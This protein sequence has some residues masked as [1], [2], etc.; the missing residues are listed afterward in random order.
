ML[1]KIQYSFAAGEFSPSLYGRVDQKKYHAGASTCRNMFINYRGGAYS[2]AGLAYVGTCLQT[3]INRNNNTDYIPRDI[4]FQFNVNQGYALEFGDQYMRIKTNGAYVTEAANAITGITKANPGVFSYTNTNYT[5][6]NG[7]WVLLSGILGMTSAT[8]VN[9]VKSFNGL[10]WIVYNVSG[11]TFSVKDLFGNP[12]DTT[13]FSTYTSGGTLKRIY[14]V[15]APYAA[16]DLP[17]L[18]FTQSADTM[19]LCCVN[20]QT[21]TE[22]PPYELVRN[23]LTNW[24]FTQ[25]NFSAPISPPTNVVAT[26]QS[27]TTISTYY[28]YV[29]TSVDAITGDE[30]VASSAASVQ[31]NDISV[32]AGSNT[33]TWTNVPAA[34]SYNVY[35]ATP[36]YNAPVGVGSSYGYIGNAFSTTFTDTNIIQNF[37]RTPPIHNNPFATKTITG[38]TIT[39]GGS[40]IV[41]SGISYTISTGTGSGL[42]AIPVVVGGALADFVIENG[43]SGYAPADTITINTNANGSYTFT[44]IPTN[45]QTIVLNGVTW[46][47]TTGVPGAASTKIQATAQA[48]V[49]Q[50]A[51]DLNASANGSINVATYSVQ[52]LILEIVYKTTGVGGNAYTLAAGTYAGTVSGATLVGGTSGGPTAALVIG[53]TAGTYPGAVA[54]FQQR[55]GYANTK[56]QPDEYFFSRPGSFTNFDSSTPSLA[57]DSVVGAPW[58]QQINGVQFMQPMTAGLIILTGQGA[59]L[60]NGGSSSAFTPSSQTATA[61][62]YNGC[63]P[64]IPPILIN[65]N[66][67]YVQEKGYLVRDLTYNFYLNVFTGDDKTIYAGHLFNFYQLTQWAW[68]E[69]PWKVVWAVRND[70]A[71]LSLT[72]LK[73]QDVFAW[74]R[75]D[76]NG[77]FVGVCTVTE[78]PVDATYVISKRFVRG[79]WMYYS[80]RMDN[81]NWDTPENCFCVDSGLSYPLTFPNATLTPVAANGTGNITS[82]VIATGG[83]GYTAPVIVAVDP[84]GAGSGATF[85]A[86]V[87][88]G[89]ITAITPTAGGQNYVQG[90]TLS[91]TDATGTGAIAYPTVTNL[92][93]FN[94][95]SG[96]FSSGSVGS[97][98]RV[99]N[100]NFNGVNQG[101]IVSGGGQAV[102]TSYVSP[103]QIVAN[104][105]QPITA[106]VPNDPN[107]TPI[108][109][110]P[111]MW[112]ITA[113]V[114]TVSG[115]NHLEGLTVSVLGDGSVV[116]NQVVTNGSITLPR[117][118]SSIIIGLPFTAQ[119]QT[120]YMEPEGSS[121][122]QGKRKNIS[123]VVVRVDN[124]R[125]FSVGTNQPDQSTQP[126]D[127]LVPWTNMKEVKERNALV[128]AGSAI[129]LFT[130]DAY[131]NVESTWDVRGQVAIQQTYPLPLNVLAAIVQ[132]VVGDTPSNT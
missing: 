125:G 36:S 84:T 52:G 38:I 65:Y 89:V 48:T 2:R 41:Q 69:E 57:D 54:Y 93:T 94:A 88:A 25:T 85:S 116:P 79:Q 19:S 40:N 102:V 16:V 118:Y 99:G 77:L 30:S 10:V 114:S 22:Y 45:T 126:N 106:V 103:T 53:P 120:L 112:S 105:T 18:K 132:Y 121:T 83:T 4:R 87:V 13:T 43:G 26:A 39:G 9:G 95:S 104:I 60:L 12:V 81:R 59:W 14:T 61:Q 21:G 131:V 92:V 124:S 119:L 37:A 96:V 109:L 1:S 28:S 33:I 117:A 90:S 3:A 15:V 66:L 75:H 5:V 108:P 107:N 73:E 80:E 97:V 35:A 82:V 127:A 58:A 62:S 27:S 91:I 24:S 115:L 70:G 122:I 123:S 31:N 34:G 51:T 128:N 100:N 56:N 42:V 6:A 67:L 72:Y 110:I 11:S 129:P 23:A 86:T 44:A 50:L 64:I 7:D 98:I 101:V 46:T 29:V 20:Q 17:Y 49:A 32:N 8:G 111:N 74:A 130:G 78:P 55:R 63:N 47:F 71:M 68:A 76:T 113:P